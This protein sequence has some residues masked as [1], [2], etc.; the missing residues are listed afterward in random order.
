MRRKRA[1]KAIVFIVL[2]F[3]LIALSPV[4]TRIGITP[5]G[6]DIT[7]FHGQWHPWFYLPYDPP[8]FEGSGWEYEPNEL[9]RLMSIVGS[10]LLT[11]LVLRGLRPETHG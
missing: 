8:L 7:Y 5:S 9:S 10:F 2:W 4:Y 1:V 6:S 11:V 3:A